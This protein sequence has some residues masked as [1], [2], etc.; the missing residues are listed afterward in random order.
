M[1]KFDSFKN[2]SDSYEEVESPIKC[3]LLI[4]IGLVIAF[5]FFSSIIL[6]SYLILI[7]L[8]KKRDPMNK[9]VITVTIT[10]FMVTIFHLPFIIISHFNCK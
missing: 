3:S 8:R 5:I 1:N 7:L 4:N 10:N 9:L 6:N 2:T